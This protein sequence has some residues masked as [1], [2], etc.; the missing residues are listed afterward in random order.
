MQRVIFAL[1]C[2]AGAFA[3]LVFELGLG[4]PGGWAALWTFAG[5]AVLGFP[6]LNLCCKR[7]WWAVWQTGLLGIVGGLLVALPYAGGTFRSDFLF[8]L[9][10][11]AGAV[12]G[13]LFWLIAIWR[14]TDLTCQRSFCLPCGIAYRVAHNALNRRKLLQSK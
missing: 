3:A 4:Q 5:V 13:V 8:L 11:V 2:V 7:R 10:V 12:L 14:N 6:L 1:M 9:F